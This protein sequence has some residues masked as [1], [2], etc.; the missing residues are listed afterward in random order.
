MPE[1]IRVLLIQPN[2][3]KYYVPFLPN[4]E[5]LVMILL[6]SI[7]EDIAEPVI[8]DRRF[9]GESALIKTLRD[10]KPDLVATRTHTSGEIFTAK[11]ILEL[12]KKV[13]P[14]T[15]TIV[16]GQHPTLLPDDLNDPCIDLICIG[17]GEKTFREVVQAKIDNSNFGNIKGLAI[18]KNGQLYYTGERPLESGAFSWPRL[19]RDLAARYRKHYLDGFTITSM[20]CPHRCNFCALWVAAQGTYRLRKPEEVIDDIAS[21]PQSFVYIGDDNTFHNYK[22]AMSICEGLKKRG[23]KKKYGAYARTD[24]IVEHRKVFEEWYKIGLRTLVV[25]MEVVNEKGLEDI[26]KRNTLENNI[27]A[28]QIL[29][30]I[31]I[32]N[33]AHFII[34]P[35]FTPRDFSD[36]WKFLKKHKISQPFFVPYTPL[37]GTPLFKEFKGKKELSIFNYGFYNLEYMVCKTT[38]PKWRWYFE[39]IKLW[40]KSISLLTFLTFRIN[41]PLSAYIFRLKML[42]RVLFPF[43]KNIIKQ[44]IEE[45]T[46]KYEDIQDKLFPSQKENYQFRYLETI[47]KM[48]HE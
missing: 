24:T 19:N 41:F 3:H 11:R 37:A 44:I 33:Y 29:N 14:P 31:G 40:L 39:Y 47:Q 42:L 43:T 38:L 36:I 4:Y 46:V 22:H 21:I 20:G 23:V 35:K 28:N 9:E 16:G 5:P 10:F 30:E 18:Q 1:K 12:A 6:A 48:K 34:F 27:K 8:F 2:F 26:N 15:T 17:P 45:K 13:H 7:V 25:G 32:Q